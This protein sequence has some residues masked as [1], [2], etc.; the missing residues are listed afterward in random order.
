MA[1]EGTWQNV[2]ALL[3]DHGLGR[4]TYALIPREQLAETR[5]LLAQVFRA[6][7]KALKE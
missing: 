3:A 5:D 4:K 2:R 6:L 1:A 7:D